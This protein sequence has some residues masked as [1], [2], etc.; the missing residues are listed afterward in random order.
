MGEGRG[1][2]RRW[3]EEEKRQI[4]AQTRIPGMTVAEVARRYEVNTSLVFSWRRDPRLGA[5]AAP[6]PGPSFVPVEVMAGA[7]SEGSGAETVV[8]M[9]L[10]NGHRVSVR[11]EL[12]VEVLEHR[13]S[14]PGLQSNLLKGRDRDLA[15]LILSDPHDEARYLGWLHIRDVGSA[16]TEDGTP[17]SD[18]GRPW[19]D[20]EEEEE[21]YEPPPDL[22][23]E[24]NHYW[25]DHV[26]T[27]RRMRHRDTPRLHL[28]D[29]ARQHAW[30]N[31]LRTLSGE[32]CDHGPIE[33]LDGELVPGGALDEASPHG[34][35]V[36]EATGNEGASLELQ[37]RSA[38]LVCWRRN[39][40]TLEMLARCG[41]RRAIAVEYTRRNSR[42]AARSEAYPLESLFKLWKQAHQTD[43]GV[44]DPVSHTL[45]IRALKTAEEEESRDR[46]VDALRDRYVERVAAVDLNAEA[47]PMLIEW[48]T[49]RLERSVPL[50]AWLRAL[51]GACAD[52][53][54]SP[55]MSGTPALVRALCEKAAT[56]LLAIEV[57][58]DRHVP[59]TN[60]D[61]AMITVKRLEEKIEEKAWERRAIAKNTAYVAEAKTVRA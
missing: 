24:N 11:G 58:S 34:A 61:E 5:E 21:A 19:K 14:E 9:A 26:P 49:Q 50:D 25:H 28:E 44:P 8:E 10:R 36:Y 27:M 22:L 38:V 45:L 57:L 37:Y 13:Y 30:I 33:V 15:R 17:W 18:E 53:W 39:P 2:R 54:R 59:P 48:I 41:A 32:Q 52:R 42:K 56:Q 47:V 12:D 43:G 31:G 3:T 6:E 29:V 4:V 60:L 16:E 46:A 23:V 35:R 55:V 1:S 40:A 51:R 20:R 7:M